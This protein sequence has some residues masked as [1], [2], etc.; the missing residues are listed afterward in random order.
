MIHVMRWSFSVQCVM[1]ACILLAGFLSQSSGQ[2]P[3]PPQAGNPAQQLPT[4]QQLPP[5]PVSVDYQM[6]IPT[7]LPGVLTPMD[8]KQIKGVSLESARID[9]AFRQSEVFVIQTY[10]LQCDSQAVGKKISLGIPFNYP[11]TDPE[12]NAKSPL[13]IHLIPFSKSLGDISVGVNQVVEPSQVVEGKHFQALAP[14]MLAVSN[15]S[16]WLTLTPTLNKG[17]NTIRIWFTAPLSQTLACKW[18]NNERR[19]TLS[20]RRFELA[21]DAF[22]TWGT[23][24]KQGELYIYSEEMLPTTLNILSPSDPAMYSR[25]DKGIIQWGFAPGNGKPQPQRFIMEWGEQFSYQIAANMSLSH[26]SFNNVSARIPQDY[27]VTASSTAPQDPFG[28][29]CNADNL[30]ASSP[31]FWAEGVDG[32]GERQTIRLTLPSPQQLK[33]LLIRT[34]LSPVRL[35]PKGDIEAQRRPDVAFS[36][37]SRPKSLII[38]LNDGQYEFKATLRDDWNEQFINVPGFTKPVQS[39]QVILDKVVRGA[40]KD[41]TSY[42]S[43]IIPVVK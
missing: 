5:A 29:P 10:I 2:D 6:T 22:S 14:S 27:T 28:Q 7:P 21:L 19:V 32:L 31:G 23:P 40:G 12:A 34:G 39:I 16:H 25:L 30:K 37:Y 9:L 4:A 17:A 42:M 38:I 8:L 24:L 36:L 3:V 26:L 1:T 43:G 15:I 11:T 20:P 18:Q 13:P 35:I 41:D 33:G